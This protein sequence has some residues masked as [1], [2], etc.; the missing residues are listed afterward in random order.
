MATGKDHLRLVARRVVAKLPAPAQ[1]A[2]RGLK[3]RVIRATAWTTWGK[4]RTARAEVRAAEA[5]A[6]RYA[7]AYRHLQSILMQV[8]PDEVG[9]I[10]EQG[11]TWEEAR[12]DRV[13]AQRTVRES[14]LARRLAAGARLEEAVAALVRSQIAVGE[15]VPARAMAQS[16]EREP[17]TRV[18]GHLG[19][20][21]VALKLQFPQMAW[22][23]FS[24][25]PVEIWRRLAAEEYF[26]AWFRVD[27]VAAAEGV[28]RL[29]AEAPPD[30]PARAWIGILKWALGAGED[31]LARE[32]F[33]AA[34]VSAATD[35][36]RWADTDAD[37]DWLRRWLGPAA[38]TTPAHLPPG[39]VGLAVVDYKQPDRAN[40]SDNVGDYL[41]TLAGLGQVVRHQNLRF[42][43]GDE[44]LATLAAELQHRVRPEL[45]LDSEPRDVHLVPVNRDATRYDAVPPGTWALMVGAHMRSVF[46]SHQF[47]PHPNL[48]PIFVSF[49]CSSPTMLTDSAVEYLRAHGPI[50]CRDWSTVDLLLSAGV[51]AFFS[52]CVT[53]TLDTIFP[54]LSA[55]DG[56]PPN[57]PTAYVD[58]SR[59]AGGAGLSH[60]SDDIRGAGLVANLRRALELLEGYRRRY[61]S[62]Q[63]SRLY[64]YLPCRSLGV[65][66]EFRPAYPADSRYNGLL[67]LGDADLEA[68]RGTLRKRLERV[69]TAIFAGATED[70]VYRIWRDECAADVEQAMA[71]RASVPAMP[72]PSFDVAAVCASVRERS[73]TIERSVPVG[74]GPDVHVALALDGNL[75]E[76]LAVVVTAMVANCSRPLHLWILSRDHDAADYARFAAVFPEVTTTWLPCDEI[77]Y[78]P[79][80][81]MLE[82]ITVATMDRL[83]L[84]ELLPELNR[85]VYHDI[86]ALP[87]GDVA[88]LDEW[89]LR[90]QPLAARSTI[91]EHVRSGFGNIMR[92]AARLRS[93]P[94]AYYDLIRRMHARFR[95]DFVP[96][97]AGI[98]VLDL[99]RMRSD[100]FC[101]E[102]LPF[103]ER[104]G[105]NDQDVL[106]CYTGPNRADL[107]REW[108]SMPTQ[109]VVAAN[110]QIVHWAGP[111][112][113]WGPEY[114]LFQEQWDTYVVRLRQREAA[115]EQQRQPVL[116]AAPAT[117]S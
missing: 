91:A 57:A 1:S 53:T 76:Q 89:D 71:R 85:I 106:N 18:A 48:R 75:K 17:N 95:Y 32:L 77:D 21:L 109:E 112:K 90:G 54:D 117:A 93:D 70:E 114:V 34:E 5:N 97:N 35:P 44:E 111:V 66:V 31:E 14:S 98:L 8:K 19:S 62:V 16:L 58:V 49:H 60:T 108:N 78:G 9:P 82:H 52:G 63:T 33:R 65:P 11:P 2:A 56:P 115:A 80:I 50:G 105:M 92:S 3:R 27:R 28:R 73:T 40:T 42:H 13:L 7:Y 104:Y 103:V 81:G 38:A 23:N 25:V 86:D 107:P 102:F 30:I 74:G 10:V 84:P 96:F 45:R 24:H 116:A 47:P 20:A 51:P 22:E 83:L 26:R 94:D 110:P 87:L 61:S 79:I 4:L 101:R 113:P 68:M 12:P 15:H 37:R 88:R 29:L 67:D 99:S 69:Y 100:N 43:S 59:P 46:G 72:P 36:A 55:D 41:Q 64:G 39:R 6:R